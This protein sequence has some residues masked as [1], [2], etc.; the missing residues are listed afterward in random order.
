M[1]NE[2]RNSANWGSEQGNIF[3]N[4]LPIEEFGSILQLIF[5]IYR[6]NLYFNNYY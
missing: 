6:I 3:N 4:A 1:R 2:D 5:V